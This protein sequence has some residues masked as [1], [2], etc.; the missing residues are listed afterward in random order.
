LK[1]PAT[2]AA[3]LG[4]TCFLAMAMDVEEAVTGKNTTL[5]TNPQGFATLT[6]AVP[7][8]ATS[9]ALMAACNRLMESTE[10]GRGW[11]FQLTTDV[12]RNPV[13]WTLRTNA[14]LPGATLAGPRG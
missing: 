10:V 9:A 14:G 2:A 6:E 4:N 7:A 11:P 13:P 5:E 12:A 3:Q 1:S 8:F